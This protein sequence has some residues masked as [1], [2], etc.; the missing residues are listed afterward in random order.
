LIKAALVSY[1]L[2]LC[3]VWIFYPEF[4][5][6]SKESL[7][8]SIA[9]WAT[10]SA[11][12]IGTFVIVTVTSIFYAVNQS[13]ALEKAKT[14]F[15][16]F[17]VLGG[18]LTAFAFL[19]E[20]VIKSVARLSRPSHSYIIRQT[21]SSVNIDSLYT[22]DEKERKAYFQELIVSDTTSF[23][24]I[25][26]RILDHWVDESGYSFPS[27]HSFN[28]YLLG[29][30]LAF[31]IYQGKKGNLK[32]L[33][34]IPMLWAFLVAVS[35]VAVGAHTALDVSVGAGMGLLFAFTLLRIT[36]TRRLLIPKEIL[37]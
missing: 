10:V 24:L 15:R 25:D 22:V 20:H 34:F 14:F 21:H 1:A 6:C 13:T 32:L 16:S 29:S 12:T 31:S 4:T 11:G 30:I 8:C 36:A 9:Y 18:M 7:W 2:L 27:G 28:A 26:Q 5:A 23:R 19:N 37:S 33:A 3:A 35:R 17:F